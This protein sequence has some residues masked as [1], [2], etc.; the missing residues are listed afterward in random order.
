[1][2]DVLWQELIKVPLLWQNVL[3]LIFST[4]F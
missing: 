2:L 4:L 1:M 3:K